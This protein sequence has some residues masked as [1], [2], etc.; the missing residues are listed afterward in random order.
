MKICLNGK[1]RETKYDP[2]LE[3]RLVNLVF[4]TRSNIVGTFLKND[5]KNEEESRGSE[6]K[7]VSRHS[8]IK[9][10]GLD[11]N[12]VAMQSAANVVGQKCPTEDS[13]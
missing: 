6:V 11:N 1:K 5:S 4:A 7:E 2:K 13:R 12:G 10:L 8:H 9:G 3:K